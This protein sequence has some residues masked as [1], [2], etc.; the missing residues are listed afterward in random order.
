MSKSRSTRWLPINPKAPV[1]SSKPS[2]LL[3]LG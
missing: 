1:T 3:S 2:P